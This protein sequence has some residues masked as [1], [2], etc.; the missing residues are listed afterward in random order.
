MGGGGG[1]T[2]QSTV[3]KTDS[4]N[5][6]LTLNK[7]FDN[8]GNVYLQS[9]P[10]PAATASPGGMDLNTKIALAALVTGGVML[11]LKR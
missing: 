7:V 11:L 4:E 2:S 9:T 1:K 8:A 5:T 3:T 6:Y 10:Q